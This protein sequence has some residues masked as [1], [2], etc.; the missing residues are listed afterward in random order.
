[1]KKPHLIALG[2]IRN[3]GIKTLQSMVDE[4]WNPE[5]PER[6]RELC[7]E[8]FSK[9]N[10]IRMPSG[11]QLGRMVAEAEALLDYCAGKGID[12]LAYGE[13]GY[14]DQLARLRRPPMIL[15]M[16]GDC[17][18]LAETRCTAVVGSRKA[19]QEALEEARSLGADLSKQGGIVVSGLA[20]G[21]DAFGHRGAL[22]RGGRTVAVLPGGIERIYPPENRELAEQIVVQGGLLMSEYP[23]RTE[24]ERW[25]FIERDRLQSGLSSR[26]VVV[27]TGLEGGTM[28]TARFAVRQGKR[29]YAR[30]W[31]RPSDS[32]G[33]NRILIEQTLAKPFRNGFELFSIMKKESSNEKRVTL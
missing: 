27:E 29:L 17:R 5:S 24:A 10:R 4:G 14:P 2:R 16:K 19:S 22:E 15:Y 20:A 1:M 31:E 8:R 30:E 11:K 33:G 9:E 28:H 7:R 18:G 3:I 12:V 13:A 21:V 6:L 25:Q 26:V 23:P 32:N